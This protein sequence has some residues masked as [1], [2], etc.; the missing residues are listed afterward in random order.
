MTLKSY[1]QIANQKRWR[2]SFPV[3][4]WWTFRWYMAELGIRRSRR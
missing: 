3:K 1:W 2:M 4:V